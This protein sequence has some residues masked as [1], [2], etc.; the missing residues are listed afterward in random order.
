LTLSA[1]KDFK[2]K[3]SDQGEGVIA[4]L[5]PYARQ[6][7][8]CIIIFDEFDS[9]FPKIDDGNDKTDVGY[10]NAFKKHFDSS[11]TNLD[12]IFI[13]AITNNIDN[14]DT[15]LLSRL[16]GK[17]QAMFVPPLTGAEMVEVFLN[18][19]RLLAYEFPLACPLNVTITKAQ[20]A[21]L[22]T[23]GSSGTLDLRGLCSMFAPIV[24]DTK[25]V[26]MALE[27]QGDEESQATA[28]VMWQ[29]LATLSD[30]NHPLWKLPAL[31]NA[32]LLSDDGYNNYPHDPKDYDE[33]GNEFGP[34]TIPDASTVDWRLL[35]DFM[36]EHNLDFPITRNDM[37]T[38]FY[39]IKQH[40]T[41]W[42]QW[43]TKY[44]GLLPNGVE[45]EGKATVLKQDEVIIILELKKAK[46]DVYFTWD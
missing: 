12:G 1:G 34:G 31:T 6:H 39:G 23:L 7:A 3:W 18:S 14:I 40:S 36:E 43:K 29:E 11:Q 33:F 2:S 17:S 5:L 8:P 10:V 4:K 22:A 19:C 20:K 27:L 45:S 42:T 46:S 41:I 16:G 25:K 21:T 30:V 38:H 15:A 24:N 44:G 9:V 13:V 26:F 28:D 37:L 35:G 32:S